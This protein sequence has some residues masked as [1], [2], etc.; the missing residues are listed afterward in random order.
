MA[1]QHL[2]RLTLLRHAHASPADAT[3]PDRDRELDHQGVRDA[4]LLGQRLKVAGARPSLIITS[5]AAR[6]VRTARIVAAA[7]GYPQEFVQREATLY[8]ATAAEILGVIAVQDDAF[9]H[10]MVCGHNPGLSDLAAALAR[11]QLESLPTA[12]LVTIGLDVRSWSGASTGGEL[13]ATDFLPSD[14][15]ATSPGPGNP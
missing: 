15:P 3:T 12:G 13:L 9:A 1:T 2:R 14:R 5:T 4:T 7:L 10:V 6:A 11:Q 8:L